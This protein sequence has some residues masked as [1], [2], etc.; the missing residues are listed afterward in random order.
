[1]QLNEEPE[2]GTVAAMFRQLCYTNRDGISAG[3]ICAG[4]D[5]TKGGQ[6]GSCFLFVCLFVCLFACF[7]FGSF[8]IF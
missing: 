4:Y 2:V 5:K 3:I 6:V 8:V 1:M 7:G